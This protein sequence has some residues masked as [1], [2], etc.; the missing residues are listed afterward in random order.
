[1]PKVPKGYHYVPGHKWKL[2]HNGRHPGYK[3][4]TRKKGKK[5]ILTKLPSNLR[6][7]RDEN[8]LFKGYKLI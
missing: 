2:G 1:M 6:G 4:K 8:G 5:R 3:R 7:V